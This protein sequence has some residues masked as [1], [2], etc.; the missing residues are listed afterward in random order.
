MAEAAR[1]TVNGDDN[2]VLCEPKDAGD[3]RVKNLDHRLD[4]EIVIA[5]AKR[6][7]FPALAFPGA[8]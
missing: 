4:L 7:H 8:V 1:T 2:F 6:S 3:S 5:G